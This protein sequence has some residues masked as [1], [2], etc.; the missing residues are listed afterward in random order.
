MLYV[1][2]EHGDGSP[3]L[4]E[5]ERVQSNFFETLKSQGEVKKGDSGVW[6]LRVGVS[7]EDQDAEYIAPLL[8][9]LAKHA[10]YLVL[11]MAMEVPVH[12]TFEALVQSDL[13]YLLLTQSPEDMYKGNL[14]IRQFRTLP[15]GGPMHL[16]PM[17]SLDYAERAYPFETLDQQLGVE[18]HGIIHGLPKDA[19][20]A[21][22]HYMRSSAGRFSAHVRKLAREIG[23]CRVGLAL[24]A[25]GA[26]ALSHIGIIQV[27]EENNIE[28]DV[29][30]GTS[31]GG[32][33]GALWSYGLNGQ[34]LENI[35]RKFEKTW[36]RLRLFD[37]VFPPMRGF[38]TRK[39][40]PANFA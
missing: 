25:G 14:L 17:I 16:L 37:P 27:L 28:V 30:A 35:V 26:K 29:V 39:T 6:E 13:P 3:N 12:V 2:F 34:E 24:S 22:S 19:H 7:G 20:E 11:H 18:V 31:M 33:V 21:R 1:A 5:W 23:R 10:R 38:F 8:S 32:M 40:H 4:S 15:S 36:Y 9:Q